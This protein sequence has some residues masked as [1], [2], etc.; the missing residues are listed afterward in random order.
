MKRRASSLPGE[1]AGMLLPPAERHVAARCSG[2]AEVPAP[3]PPSPGNLLP[4]RA[5][6]FSRGF[7]SAWYRP[8][9][10]AFA[11]LSGCS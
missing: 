4:A 3:N 2:G 6:S 8:R 10:A 1:R 11:K 7:I 5:D 9:P